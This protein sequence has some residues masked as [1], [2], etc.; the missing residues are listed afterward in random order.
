MKKALKFL[1]IACMAWVSLA[2]S[3]AADVAILVYH[4]FGEAQYPSTNTT[5]AQLD[6]HIALLKSGGYEFLSLQDLSDRLVAGTPLPDQGVIITVDDAFRSFKDVGWPRFKQAGIP[7]TLFV[8]T[9]PVASARPGGNYLTWDDLKELSAEGVTLGHHAASHR[10]LPRM[11]L[12]EAKADINRATD[13]FVEHLG[14]RPD[15]FAY[16]Y[17]EFNEAL[18]K[19]LESEGFI[20]GIAQYSGAVGLRTDRFALPRFPINERYGNESR[21][22]LVSRAMALPVKDI[23]PRDPELLPTQNPPLFGFTLTKSIPGL[24][25]L[26]CYPSHLADHNPVTFLE[27]KSGVK[28]VELRFDKPFPKGRSRINC[29]MQGQNGRWYW[30]G[31][32]FFVPGGANN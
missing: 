8:S 11:P 15:I 20:L 1:V 12:Q 19:F 7:V 6:T 2:G 9:D 25:N 4:R 31:R 26:R 13:A 17:G 5:L 10:H 22:K 14:Y 28:R 29:T 27:S 30:F 32:P 24:K 23:L 3:V 18:A 21:F 16:P